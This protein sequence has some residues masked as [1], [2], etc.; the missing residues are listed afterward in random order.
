[1][2]YKLLAYPNNWSEISSKFITYKILLFVFISNF[3]GLCVIGELVCIGKIFFKNQYIFLLAI[4]SLFA[5]RLFGKFSII[6][7][8]DRKS[9]PSELQSR[10]YLVCRLLLE[11]KKQLHTKKPI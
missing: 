4:I 10:Q 7:N 5:S 1:M 9:T 8:Q 11:K 2:I 6:L 3:L